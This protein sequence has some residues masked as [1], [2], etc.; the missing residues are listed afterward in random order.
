MAS[1][2]LHLES[3]QDRSIC[4]P[5]LVAYLLQ[6]PSDKNAAPDHQGRHSGKREPFSRLAGICHLTW[7][8]VLPWLIWRIAAFDHSVFRTGWM[9][10]VA[11]TIT[12]SLVFD[13]LDAARYLRGDKKFSWAE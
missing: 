1:A 8:A 6:G 4:S 10:Y 7:I 2:T 3:D 9:I 5:A 12:I 11:A 13:F